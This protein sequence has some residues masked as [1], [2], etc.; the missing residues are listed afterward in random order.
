MTTTDTMDYATINAAIRTYTEAA[1][2]MADADAALKRAAPPYV[3]RAL[4]YK[5]A[6]PKDRAR[7]ASVLPYLPGPGD[8]E[9]V[10][11]SPHTTTG[12][13]FLEY[14]IPAEHPDWI[15]CVA[16]L[17][18]RHPA[19]PVGI[20]RNGSTSIGPVTG[21]GNEEERADFTLTT[22]APSGDYPHNLTVTWWTSPA[23]G[24]VLEIR[25]DA[26]PWAARRR[27]MYH[28]D[29]APKSE[30]TR[31][32]PEDRKWSVSWTWGTGSASIKWWTSP[33]NKPRMTWTWPVGTDIGHAIGEDK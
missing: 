28:L 25:V 22:D 23:P 29:N 16:G 7:L 30:R 3:V 17:R 13:A 9:P 33:G 2:A 31:Q 21:N 27:V 1:E 32:H 4:T 11:L 24:V 12:A 14:E 15:A 5:T 20:R 6:T 26:K 19:I 18:A 10:T 8:F